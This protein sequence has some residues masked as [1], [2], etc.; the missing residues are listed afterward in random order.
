MVYV[1]HY[2]VN[3]FFHFMYQFILE[4]FIVLIHFQILG[5]LVTLF[6]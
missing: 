3:E 5:C 1:L 2:P 6:I 4:Y